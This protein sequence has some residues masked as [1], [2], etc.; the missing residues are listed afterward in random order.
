MD[1]L[2][3]ATE[4]EDQGREISHMEVGQP[5]TGAPRKVIEAAQQAL[6]SDK[7]GYTNA[8]G[9]SPLRNAIVKHYADKYQVTITP[10]QVV[11]CTGSSAAFLFAFLGCFDQGDSVGICSSGYPCYRNIMKA[12]GLHTVNIP[13]NGEFKITAKELGAEVTRRKALQLSPLKGLILSSPS[14]PTGAMLSP[15]ELQELC[16]LCDQENILFMSDEIYHGISYGRHQEETALK[17]SN[18]AVVIN[19][20]SKYYSMTGWRLGWMVVPPSLVDAMNRLSQNM[21]INAPTLSQ[22]AAT[23]AFECDDELQGHI[24]KYR[25]NRDCVLRT[26]KELGLEEGCS[27]A[28]GAFYVYVD[29]SASGVNDAP[30]LCRQILEE[31]GVAITPGSDFEDPDSGL[32]LKRIRFSYSRS[33]EEVEKGMSKFKAWWIKNKGSPSGSQPQ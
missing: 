3:R 28:D 12:T 9:I 26:L 11:V 19:S 23:H 21:Y 10:A 25:Q 24:A 31:A 1:V 17:F 2:H 27:P 20:F 4:L 33:T 18:S 13:I 6:L 5:S 16:Q 7:I 14:N 30:A 15:E 32:G 29:L 8:L 22:L